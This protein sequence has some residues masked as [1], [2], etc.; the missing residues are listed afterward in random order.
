MLDYISFIVHSSAAGF[1]YW[2]SARVHYFGEV[3]AFF[4]AMSRFKHGAGVNRLCVFLPWGVS[5][6]L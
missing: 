1:A 4:R 2:C 5:W 3:L 6:G